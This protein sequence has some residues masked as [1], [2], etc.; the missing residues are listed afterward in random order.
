MTEDLASPGPRKRVVGVLGG[1][2]PSATADF[3]SKVIARTPVER[4]ADHLPLVVWSNP[5]IPDRTNALLGIG[6]SPV[7]AMVDGAQRLA[8]AGA[9]LIVMPCNTA[10]AFLGELR[11][12]VGIPFV[13][14]VSTTVDLIRRSRP[15]VARVG[16]LA[17]AGTRRAGLYAA[18]CAKHQLELIDLSDEDQA[19]LVTPAIRAVKVGGDLGDAEAKVRRAARLLAASGAEV[20]IAGCT[21]IPLIASGAAT[22]LPIIDSTAC[23]ADEVV[24]RALFPSVDAALRT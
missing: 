6:P 21:E 19:G 14:M 12:K 22:V 2:G 13:D 15:S 4:E 23:L 16:L 20:L 10:H 24:R 8:A 17:T 3:I 18:E 7:P 1:M 11:P 5:E 9:T